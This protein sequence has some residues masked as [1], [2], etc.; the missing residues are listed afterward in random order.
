MWSFPPVSAVAYPKAFYPA[1][2]PAHI[3]V[4]PGAS[5]E[6]YLIAYSKQ[7]PMLTLVNYLKRA[8]RPMIQQREKLVD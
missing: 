2:A 4:Y 8:G 7:P 3:E 1:N 5:L 6:A